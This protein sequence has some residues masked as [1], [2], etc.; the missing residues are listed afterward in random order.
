MGLIERLHYKNLSYHKKLLQLSCWKSIYTTNYD[1]CLELSE[2]SLKNRRLIPIVDGEDGTILRNR[3]VNKLKYFKIHGCSRNLEYSPEKAPPLVLTLRDFR[4]SLN[5]KRP[6]I[7][8]L[9]NYLIDYQCSI[10]FIGFSVQYAEND[11]IL[12]DIQSSYDSI[13]NTIHQPFRP[14]AVLRNVDEDTRFDL[15]HCDIN[16]L[17]GSFENFV[18]EVEKIKANKQQEIYEYVETKEKIYITAHGNTNSLTRELVE[19]NINQFLIYY[20]SYLDEKR[21]QEIGISQQHLIDRWKT[22][23]S[24]VFLATQRYIKRSQFDHFFSELSGVVNEVQTTKSSHIFHITWDRA[25]GKTVLVKQLAI[26]IFE[27]L[28]VPVIILNPNASTC[29]QENGKSVEIQGWD[30]RLIDKFIS[31]INHNQGNDTNPPVTLLVADHLF[32]KQFS[33]DILLKY[34]ENHN[35]PCV[36]LLTSNVSSSK[37]KEKKERIFSLYNMTKFRLN[38]YLDD[39]EIDDLFDSVKRDRSEIE[40][41]RQFLINKAKNDCHR[42]LLFILYSWFDH[43]FRRLEEIIIE[44]SAKLEKESTAL[45]GLYLTVALF[46]QYNYSP[47]IS[48]C[49]DALG[50]GIVEF[51]KLSDNPIFKSFLKLFASSDECEDFG[52]L[53]FTR[54]PEFA[55]R[56]IRE[57]LPQSDKQIEYISKVIRC[58]KLSDLQFIQNFLIMVFVNIRVGHS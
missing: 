6:L 23:H 22:Q 16:L 10:V 57:L 21:E 39:I 54:H 55:R 49:A 52:H 38:Q 17:E 47:R 43:N 35:K 2:D 36:L 1:I 56:I 31:N 25:S 42:D 24:D 9:K 41:R 12:G 8:E 27:Q 34:L 15:E 33:I 19:Q 53:A 5:R 20:D 4:N 13:A 3:D 37:N 26:H 44:E 30:V 40:S 7:E 50:I 29:V 45:R 32:H 58:T 48:L 28:N 14:F 46:H 51:Q 11:V 18:D